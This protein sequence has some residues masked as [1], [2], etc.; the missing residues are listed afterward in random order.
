VHGFQK[1]MWV[2]NIRCRSFLY[3]IA[4]SRL[5]VPTIKS[6]HP[7]FDPKKVSSTLAV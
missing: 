4:F 2:K 1:D 5:L 3:G 6:F 7:A